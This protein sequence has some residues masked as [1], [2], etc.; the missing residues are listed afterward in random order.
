MKKILSILFLAIFMFP[1]NEKREVKA[2]GEKVFEPIVKYQFN[3]GELGKDLYGNYDLSIVGN[4]K[5]GTYGV[6]LDGNSYLY[7]SY[8]NSRD[9]TDSLSKFTVTLWAKEVAVGGSHRFILGTGCAYS[10][11]GFGMGFYAGNSAYIVPNGSFNAYADNFVTSQKENFGTKVPNYNTS[12]EWNLFTIMLRNGECYFGVNGN[13]YPFSGQIDINL[14]KNITQTFTIGAVCSNNGSSPHNKFAGE[15]A[16]VR[17]YNDFLTQQEFNTIFEKGINGEESIMRTI[18]INNVDGSAAADPSSEIYPYDFAVKTYS[19]T[20]NGIMESLKDI[21]PN[22]TLS[23]GTNVVANVLWGK[24]TQLDTN[25]VVVTGILDVPGVHKKE[26]QVLVSKHEEARISVN[27]TFS[28][29]MV[30]QRN[31]NV[32]IFGYGGNVGEEV[33]VTFNGQTKRGVIDENGWEVYLDPM[34]ANSIGSNLVITY[35]S[36]EIVYQDVVVGEVLLCSGQSNMEISIQYIDNKDRTV[37]RQYYQHDN[38]DKIRILSL[39]FLAA[40]SPTIY[41]SPKAVWKKCE[42]LDK[43]YQYSAYAMATASNYQAIL[44]DVVVGVIVAAVGGSCIEEWIDPTSMAKLPSYAA[45]MGKVNSQYYNGFIH[46]L[47]GYTISGIVWYQGESNSQPSMVKSYIRQ[48]NAYLSL[49][50]R[51][52]E[53]E[54]LPIVVQQLVQ[55]DNWCET[56]PFRQMQWDLMKNIEGVYVV[57][58]IDTGDMDPVDGIH[59]S[60]KWVLGKRA[61]GILAMING[62]AKEDFAVKNPYGVSKD[63]TK[64][65]ILVKDEMTTITFDVEGSPTLKAKGTITGFQVKSGNVW[66]YVEANI[67]EGV[68]TIE[69]TF[70]NIV[71]IRYNY[72]NGYENGVYVYDEEGLPLAPNADIEIMIIN[73]GPGT[74]EPG[75]EDPG[76]TEPGTEDPGT[77][78][79]GTEGPSTEDPGKDEPTP[80][81]GCKG[82]IFASLLGVVTLLNS[83]VVIRFARRKKNEIA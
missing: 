34:E 45:S 76:T 32:K 60:D 17:I 46:N 1:L 52:F 24:T 18:S 20:N 79:P 21:A 61:A 40:T 36:Q 31:K 82:S 78:E 44:G 72:G 4:P 71:G 3:E 41:E 14:I 8:D 69:T 77:T 80:K 42:S 81:K 70:K 38:Y 29:H 65:N 53:D 83:V 73:D 68:I 54:T 7:S 15:I 47:A 25:S 37:K 12:T 57:N 66:N 64:A 48:F 27:T 22:V 13:L 62:I 30:L 26:I 9:V 11:D 55:W 6:V 67:V 59:P 50:R 2:V 58:G 43:S 39:P 56:G 16:D 49:Y 51:I 75:T 33:T 19:L 28:N 63:I 35:G 10:Q 23:D 5:K 74:E